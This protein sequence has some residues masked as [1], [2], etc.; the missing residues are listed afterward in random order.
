MASWKRLIRELIL[1]IL[2][3]SF[4]KKNKDMIYQQARSLMYVLYGIKLFSLSLQ[5]ES[6]A[7][8]VSLLLFC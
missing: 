8:D 1:L 3:E 4:W 2:L 5:N 7:R 6:K